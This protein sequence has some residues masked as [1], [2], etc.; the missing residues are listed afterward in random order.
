MA[1]LVDMTIEKDD[2]QTKEAGNAPTIAKSDSP[3]YPYGLA[4]NLDTATVEKLGLE[5]CEVGDEYEITAK[6]KVTSISEN[7]TEGSDYNKT[8]SLQITSM[9][10]DEGS[11][12][13]DNA[14]GQDKE[15]DVMDTMESRMADS[16][17]Y[18]SK[19]K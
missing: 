8:I 6:A 15:K 11:G 4:L 2:S 19:K 17:A 16:I 10:V 9:S 1:N 13:E 12:N 7:D 18:V 5:G 3:K 14:V